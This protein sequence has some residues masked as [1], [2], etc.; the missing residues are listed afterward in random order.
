M[1]KHS[2]AV[3]K[4]WANRKRSITMKKL[5]Q[6]KKKS[7]AMKAWW[8]KR[9]TQITENCGCGCNEKAKNTVT[10]PDMTKKQKQA[11]Y[12]A[13]YYAKK[14]PNAPRAVM[15][16]ARMGICLNPIPP[17][18]DL[19]DHLSKLIAEREALNARIDALVVTKLINELHPAVKEY[20][21]KH[22][23]ALKTA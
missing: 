9:K 16:R 15:Y 6:A 11:I 14:H 4:G 8:A 10:T 23:E 7:I 13:R 3:R 21:Q 18:K 19:S 22:P 1:N 17:M 2:K 20:L 12:D 5:H